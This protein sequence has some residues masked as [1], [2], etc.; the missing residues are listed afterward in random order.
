M[1]CTCGTVP[2]WILVEVSIIDGVTVTVS[3][4]VISVQEEINFFNNFFPP[5]VNFNSLMSSSSSNINAGPDANPS[6]KR[7]D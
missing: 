5:T 2:L 6:S 1:T 3:E 4:G 7:K